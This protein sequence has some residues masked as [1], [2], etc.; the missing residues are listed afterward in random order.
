M[1][2][3]WQ[4]GK[5]ETG[6]LVLECPR[7]HKHIHDHG[8]RTTGTATSPIHTDARRALYHRRPTTR[9]TVLTDA[10]LSA[11]SRGTRGSAASPFRAPCGS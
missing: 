3:V 2:P 11:P 1:V 6:N 9:P 10:A 8:I 5:T 7:H 4:G